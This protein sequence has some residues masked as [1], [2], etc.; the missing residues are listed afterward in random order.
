MLG[1]PPRSRDPAQPAACSDGNVKGI[2]GPG[3]QNL[4]EGSIPAPGPIFLA[5]ARG[6]C[7]EAVTSPMT[8]PDPDPAIP[9]ALGARGVV[10]GR[11]GRP[12]GHRAL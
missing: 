12:G 8:H 5:R 3:P 4:P 10:M 9:C 7:G 1:F 2:P 6:Y 11:G